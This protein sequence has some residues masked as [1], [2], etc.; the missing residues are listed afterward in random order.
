MW[1]HAL[2]L[3]SLAPLSSLQQRPAT[4]PPLKELFVAANKVAVIEGL[5]DLTCLTLLELGSNRIRVIENLEVCWHAALHTLIDDQ[6]QTQ[7]RPVT[8]HQ[9]LCVVYEFSGRHVLLLLLLLLLVVVVVFNLLKSG[10]FWS[11]VLMNLCAL[12]APGAGQS[13]RALAWSQSDQQV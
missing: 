3:R 6:K 5:S 10:T 11:V 12:I 1:V 13:C 7:Q 2:Q 4:T 8:V 9:L